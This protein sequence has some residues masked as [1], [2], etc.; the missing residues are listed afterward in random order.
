LAFREYDATLGACLDFR[1]ESCIKALMTN[2]GVEELRAVVHYQLLQRQLL[3]V[4]VLR[5]QTC[6]D[7]A[8]QGLVELEELLTHKDEVTKLSHPITVPGAVINLKEVL[9]A[10]ADG[11]HAQHAKRE[12]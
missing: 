2:L 10:A 1:S 5:N 4:A 7:G 12:V 8:C 6:M 9:S 11:A 3:T